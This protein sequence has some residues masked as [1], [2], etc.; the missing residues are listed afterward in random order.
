MC[1]RREVKNFS[2]TGDSASNPVVKRSVLSV[3]ID[4]RCVECVCLY[5]GRRVCGQNYIIICDCLRKSCT[6]VE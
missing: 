1:I 3:F 6:T 4:Q 2:D 5:Y